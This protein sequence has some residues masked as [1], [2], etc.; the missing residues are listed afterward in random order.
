MSFTCKYCAILCKGLQHPE[1]LIA[2][3]APEPVPH[4]YQGTT[5]FYFRITHCVLL[6]M[7]RNNSL[8]MICGIMILKGKVEIYDCLCDINLSC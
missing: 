4:G 2:V 1:I 6:Q 5:A 7:P 8:Q 3:R